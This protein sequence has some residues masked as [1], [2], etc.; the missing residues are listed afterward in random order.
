MNASMP[1]LSSSILQAFLLGMGSGSTSNKWKEYL[2][3]LLMEESNN[4]ASGVQVLLWYGH[5]NGRTGQSVATFEGSSCCVLSGHRYHLECQQQHRVVVVVADVLD[6]S[7]VTFRIVN[8]T[9]VFHRYCLAKFC[10]T[11][12]RL[13]RTASR[14]Q[15]T[16][17]CILFGKRRFC[18]NT[19][20]GLRF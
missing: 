2:L 1:S 15:S 10:E 13:N 7:S 6:Q 4:T 18:N 8:A 12:E 5:G 17:R 14:F 9:G 16:R 11:S 3:K 20:Y 19:Y